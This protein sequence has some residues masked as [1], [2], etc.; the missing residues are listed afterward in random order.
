VPENFNS[1]GD[2]H[3]TNFIYLY[4]MEGL[5]PPIRWAQRKDRVFLTVELRD[6]KN[7]K[8]EWLSPSELKFSGTS[9]GKAYGCTINL[10][11]D[12]NIEESKWN[13]SGLHMQFNLKKKEDTFWKRLTKED[14][15]YTHIAV[16]WSKWVDEDEEEEEGNKGLGQ[17][18]N[19]D[20]MRGFGG[21]PGM[22]GMGGMGMPGMGGMGGMGMPGMGG[23]GGMGMDDDDHDHQGHG[24]DHDSDSDDEEGPGGKKIDDLEKDEEIPTKEETKKDLMEEETKI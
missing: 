11:A 9:D 16:D 24:H 23:M 5:T 22:G 17:D 1:E 19:P 8:V 7:E 4:K 21:M 13:V 20:N 2:N 15:K 18:W 10:F 6:I 14:K 3:S 12:S